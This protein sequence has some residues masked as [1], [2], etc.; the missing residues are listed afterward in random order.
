MIKI[1]T[2]T[3][4]IRSWEG[5]EYQG[6]LALNIALLNLC[7]LIENKCD[8]SKWNLQIEGEED[9]SILEDEKYKTIHQ[10][11][12]GA[13]SL[14]DN[15]KFA[16]VIGI[17]QNNAE[18]GYFHVNKTQKIPI[19]FLSTSLEYAKQLYDEFDKPLKHRKDLLPADKEDEYI[20]IEKI[21]IQTGKANV[22]QI[23]NYVCDG[24]KDLMSVKNE[25][26]NIQ[27][28]L[29]EFENEINDKILKYKL[30]NPT[31]KEDECVLSEW[32]EKYD[33]SKEV[34]N[35]S[36]QIIHQ[37]IEIEHHEWGFA[38]LEYCEFVYDQLLA[39]LK[40]HITEFF[41]KN[42]KNGDCRI[43]FSKI[44]KEVL[45]DYASERETVPYN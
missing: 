10:A 22:Y 12:I 24:R 45:R 27:A 40:K 25:I 36:V 7:E 37:I 42:I 3:N 32:Y 5:Y 18:H 35:K 2:P 20:V 8:F 26:A 21:K 9:F 4:A 11:K 14:E 17:L 28:T 44:H 23:L 29:K 34:I 38:D 39:T 41:I 13:V 6:H 43:S 31:A 1:I 16:F 15:D 19:N 30:R 33:N